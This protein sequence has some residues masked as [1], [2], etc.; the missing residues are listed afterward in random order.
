M[1]K[2]DENL[3]NH[4]FGVGIIRKIILISEAIIKTLNNI[5]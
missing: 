4:T 1:L 3:N 5:F 2:A